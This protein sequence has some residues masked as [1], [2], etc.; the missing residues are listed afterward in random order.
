MIGGVIFYYYS[1]MLIPVTV[2]LSWAVFLDVL[3][4]FLLYLHCKVAFTIYKVNHR[5][6]VSNTYCII[7]DFEAITNKVVEFFQLFR[8]RNLRSAWKVSFNYQYYLKLNKEKFVR[9][10]R[11]IHKGGNDGNGWISSICLILQATTKGLR[12]SKQTFDGWITEHEQTIV[13]HYL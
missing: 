8:H 10:Q 11:Y 13:V 5:A 12:R 9:V 1:C 2:Q 7:L 3:P 4:Q 6:Q